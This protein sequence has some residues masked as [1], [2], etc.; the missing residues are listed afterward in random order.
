M[1]KE[2]CENIKIIKQMQIRLKYTIK[3]VIFQLQLKMEIE[4]REIRK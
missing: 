1:I 3:I 4:K 2:R